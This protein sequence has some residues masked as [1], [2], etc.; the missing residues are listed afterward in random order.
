MSVYLYIYVKYIYTYKNKEHHRQL[1][2][3]HPAANNEIVNN[4]KER[5]SKE[6][7][8]TKNVAEGLKTT[9]PRTRRV[10]S[11]FSQ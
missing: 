5:L 3:D 8:I 7:L 6:N 2:K 4:V 10:D 9:S 1:S 11:T